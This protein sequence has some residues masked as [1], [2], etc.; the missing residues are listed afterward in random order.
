MKHLDSLLERKISP[1]IQNI[2]IKK[3][4][5]MDLGKLRLRLGLQSAVLLLSLD[6]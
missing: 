6:T 1:I 5:Y 2:V 3:E 4:V